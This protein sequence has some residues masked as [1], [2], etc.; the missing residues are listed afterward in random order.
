MLSPLEKAIVGISLNKPSMFIALKR[1]LCKHTDDYLEDD[2]GNL[3][4]CLDCGYEPWLVDDEDKARD[5][6]I[7][8]D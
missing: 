7:T 5:E 8:L 2:D 6:E 4:R 3:I 1:Q